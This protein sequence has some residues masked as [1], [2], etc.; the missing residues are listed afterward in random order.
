MDRQTVYAGQVPLETDLLNTNRN[1]LIA[2]GKMLGDMLG[3]STFAAGLGCGPTSPASMNVQIQPGQLYA[4]QNLDNNPYSSLPADTTHQI[5]KQGIALNAQSFACSAPTTAGYSINYLIEA[6]YADTD[7]NPVVLPFYNASNPSQAF[8]G[9]GGN[10]QP[11]MTTRAGQVIL[12][13]KPGVAAAT[14]SQVTPAVD[15]G[16]VGLWVVTVAYGQSTITASNIS[17]YPSAPILPTSLLQSLITNNLE[18]G[19]DNGNANAMQATFPIAPTAVV[20]NQQFWVKVK[21]ANTGAT[22]FTPNPGVIGALP[23]VGAAHQALQGGELVASGRA[24]LV[25]RADIASYVLESCTGAALQTAPATQ[26]QHAVQ[27]GQLGN[28]SARKYVNGSGTLAASDSGSWVEAGGTGPTTITLPAP[29]TSNLTY[30]VTNVTSNGTAVTISTPSA[31]IYN[32]AAASST[33][34]LDVGATVDLVS[35][36]SNWTVISHYTRSQIGQTPAQF[37]SSSKLAT[38][39]F[40]Q[41][42]LGNFGSFSA[43]NANTTLSAFY[44][45]QAIQWYGASGGVLTLPSGASMPSGGAF[46]FFNFGSGPITIATQG[47]DF[48]W[49]NGN[50]QPVTLQV[51]DSLL[52]VARGSTEWDVAGGTA[53]IQFT[54][55][56]GVTAAQFDNS[57]RLATTAFVQRATGGVVG[58]VRNAFMSVGSASASA[59]FTADEIAV[60]TALGGAAFRIANFNATINLATTGAGGMDTGSAPASGFVA[61]YAIYNP[62]TQTATLL[63]RNATAGKVSEV[64]SGSYMPSGYTASAL[65]SVWPTNASGQFIIGTQ[66]DR[67]VAIGGSVALSTT[68]VVST[69]TSLSISSIV[70][71]NARRISGYA[72]PGNAGA[73][74]VVISVAA[75]STG[76]KPLSVGGYVSNNQ[77]QGYF[78][79]PLLVQ[80]TMYY[81]TSSTS[82]SPNFSIVVSEYIF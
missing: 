30:T 48:I 10:G 68:T 45:G 15:S 47:A 41:R 82:G 66:V 51:G 72:Q 50:V 29:S 80:Q 6:N 65:V 40:V 64:Y 14:G 22:T 63:A 21:A 32:Q 17:Q 7:T 73:A 49:S 8:N 9:P 27:L 57:T 81:S 71:P 19:I 58:A 12:T 5:V 18:Y 1:V 3:T 37:D 56:R 60:E 2:L 67:A 13:L 4:L 20:D 62:T 36:A 79:I 35:D 11:S 39:A 24:L 46:L 78:D 77:T 70:P 52:L 74:G 61:L 28:F 31:S 59:T 25:Y 26:S 54:Q 42:A 33:F 76:M 23:V 16:C 69:L 34:S 38:T 75:T 43:F 55:A 53:A 44:A